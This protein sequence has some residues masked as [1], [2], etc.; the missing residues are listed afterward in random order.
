MADA[1]LDL[2]ADP[3]LADVSGQAPL[4]AAAEM[5][6]LAPMVGRPSPKLFGNLEAPAVVTKLLDDGRQPECGPQAAGAR[7]ATT[8]WAA[9]PRWGRA[10]RR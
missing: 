1:L 2:K 8:T 3:N 9:T 4:Y 7:Q 5:H 6:T 10:P